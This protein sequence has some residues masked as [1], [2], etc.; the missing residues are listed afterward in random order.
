M[1][2]VRPF[3][4]LGRFQ[5]DWLNARHHFSFGNYHDESR[6]GLG[7][8]RVWNDDQIAP[9]TGFDPHPHRDM[10]IITYVRSGAITH[11]DSLGNEGRTQAGDVQVMHAGRG[12][13]HAEYNLEQDETRIFQIWLTPNRRGIE[14]GWNTRTFP[15][16][17]EGVRVLAAGDGRD[18]ALPLYADG[19]VLAGRLASG[20]TLRHTL[21]PG[22]LAYLVP[23]SGSLT[24]NGAK[25]GARDGAA[26]TGETELTITA[27]EPAEL[28]L[29]E[30]I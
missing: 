9:G 17:D 6:M 10:E 14:P 12:I 4:S 15:N 22:Q 19:A 20:Q 5:N 25:I 7:A 18:G 28:V 29:V 23:A 13:V 26:I 3:S 8:L 1:I 30:T 21:A 24:V 2:D 11:R 27:D 16:A